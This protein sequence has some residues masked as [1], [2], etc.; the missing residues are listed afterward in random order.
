MAQPLRVRSGGFDVEL[1]VRYDYA[2]L[3]VGYERRFLNLAPAGREIDYELSYSRTL[4][5]GDFG[6]HAFLRTDPGHVEA[7]RDDIG[8]AIRFTRGF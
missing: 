5:G 2:S 4:L 8:A 3:G 1:P 6:A 7:R